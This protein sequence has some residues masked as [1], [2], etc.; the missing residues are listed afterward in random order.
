MAVRLV[1]REGRVR[2]SCLKSVVITTF[3]SYQ[4]VHS[5]SVYA[6]VDNRAPRICEAAL[7]LWGEG[8]RDQG[9]RRREKRREVL[10][11]AA[12]F[13]SEGVGF[14]IMAG[15]QAQCEA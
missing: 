11:S 3:G 10:Q 5:H 2:T 6:S 9:E 1:P 8:G 14:V 15:R 13:T 12:A 4:Y 7:R